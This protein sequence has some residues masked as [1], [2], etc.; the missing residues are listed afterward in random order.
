[1]N[2]TEWDQSKVSHWSF[3]LPLLCIVVKLSLLLLFK[4]VPCFFWAGPYKLFHP[5]IPDGRTWSKLGEHGEH[6]EHG[7]HG[8]DSKCSICQPDDSKHSL[9]QHLWRWLKNHNK[10]AHDPARVTSWWENT[11]RNVEPCFWG[12][13][14]QRKWSKGRATAWRRQVIRGWKSN[15]CLIFVS[16]TQVTSCQENRKNKNKFFLTGPE[17]DSWS[18]RFVKEIILGGEWGEG[19]LCL[20]ECFLEKLWF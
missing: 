9:I 16:S 8:K 19:D 10:C 14:M 11:K 3:T 15:L 18:W 1:M 5:A 12:I 2:K 17:I 20:R 4:A 13:L 6:G 7:K